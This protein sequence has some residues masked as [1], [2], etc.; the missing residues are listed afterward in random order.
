MSLERRLLRV[1][2]VVVDVV[3]IV[4]IFDV[5]TTARVGRTPRRLFLGGY[6]VELVGGR[7]CLSLTCSQLIADRSCIDR[8]PPFY[9]IML[10]PI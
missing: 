8:R 10:K 7:C 6:C 3:V 4:L 5:L 9:L 2:V 1:V